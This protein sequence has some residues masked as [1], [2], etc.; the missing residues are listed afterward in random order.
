MNTCNIF[1]TV[2]TLGW[3]Q[4]DIRKM[5]CISLFCKWRN[6]TVFLFFCKWRNYSAFFLFC[7]WRNYTAFC[8]FA[9]GVTALHFF[10]FASDVSTLHLLSR[11][12]L[13]YS[14]CDRAMRV[15]FYSKCIWKKLMQYLT[16]LFPTVHFLWALYLNK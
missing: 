7:K 15:K 6:S 9:S 10:S 16:W 3:Y 14:N 2:Q 4:L 13:N 8:Y 1:I 5:L 11:K 12:R